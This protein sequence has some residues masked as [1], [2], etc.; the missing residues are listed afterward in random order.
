[1]DPKEP[2]S[3]IMTT[4]VQYVQ[5]NQSLSV[6]RQ[7]LTENDIQHVPVLDGRQLVGMISS[8]DLVKL[9]IVAHGSE[10]LIHTLIDQQFTTQQVMQTNL[11]CLNPGHT[12]R[13]AAEIL[14]QSKFHS[15][16]VV[17]VNRHLV[18]ILTTTDLL[19][20]L[21]NQY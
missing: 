3:N 18:G 19:L 20:Y 9:N 10:K 6:V 12:I 5:D 4:D 2:I 13:E 1:M 11:V 8:T 21:L 14:A 15:L 17:D 16:P 7:I